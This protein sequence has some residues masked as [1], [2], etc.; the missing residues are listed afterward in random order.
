MIHIALLRV[1]AFYSLAS[2]AQPSTAFPT[3]QAHP[4]NTS[5]INPAHSTSTFSMGAA[6]HHKDNEYASASASIGHS[7]IGA[8]PLVKPAPTDSAVKTNVAVGALVTALPQPA[9]TDSS[10][11]KN[12]AIDSMATA[13]PQTALASSTE[14]K[15]VAIGALATALPQPVPAFSNDRK[16]VTIGALTTAL[17]QPAPASS[18]VKTNVAIGAQATALPQSA[19]TSSIEKKNVTIGAL[20]TALPQPAPSSSIEKKNVA[21]GALT[22]A[23]PQP[24]STN[25]PSNAWPQYMNVPKSVHDQ[26]IKPATKMENWSSSSNSPSDTDDSSSIGGKKI[27][28]PPLGFQQTQPFSSLNGTSMFTT[29]AS[30]A[31]E[32]LNDSRSEED[33]IEAAV[34]N[35]Y[36]KPASDG[37]QNLVNRQ[38]APNVSNHPSAPKVTVQSPVA[39]DSSWSTSSMGANYAAPNKAI[40]TLINQQP[41]LSKKP[42]ESTW[43]DSRP[44]SA[45]LKGD[46]FRSKRSSYSGSSAHSDDEQMKGTV[47]NAKAPANVTNSSIA[48]LVNKTIRPAEPIETKGTGVENLLHIM[49]AMR[50]SAPVKQTK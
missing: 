18:T 46:S 26:T 42:S 12:V 3:N 5:S 39:D 49:E 2:S 35:F 13:L 1:S 6:P 8:N 27:R 9:L 24:G 32:K 14:R 47:I 29:T 19:P 23:L 25:S 15:N 38:V 10:V 43:D 21:I 40:S 41:L 20:A 11:K 44:L 4:S 45:D 28:T 36:R 34:Q 31:K 17:P 37:I 7:L 16:N 48:Q 30:P 50:R 22:T 33:S